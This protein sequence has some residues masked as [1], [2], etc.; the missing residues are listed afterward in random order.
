MQKGYSCQP[1]E[2]IDLWL[3]QCWGSGTNNQKSECKEARQLGTLPRDKGID[4]QIRKEETI[5]SLWR[6]LLS[7]MK[8]RYPFR[9]ELF[10][11]Q[12]K[13]T[14]AEKGLQHLGELE[15]MK[16]IYSDLDD[17][18]VSKDLG[19]SLCIWAT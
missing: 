10:N 13:W 7:S 3:L 6:Q 17:N 18:K 4:R 16:V 5:R 9:K 12:G 19:D 11:Y 14:T 1:G 8:A 2:Q 15:V